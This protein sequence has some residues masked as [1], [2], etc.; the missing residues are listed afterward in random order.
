[1]MSKALIC[2]GLN[3]DALLTLV[4][5]PAARRAGKGIHQ[6]RALVDSLPLRFASAGNDT[7]SG[8]ED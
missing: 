6:L 3:C 4:S 8:E 1:M 7:G 5:S 2:Y